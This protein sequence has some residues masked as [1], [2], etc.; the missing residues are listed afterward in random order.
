MTCLEPLVYAHK[1]ILAYQ[2]LLRYD[3]CFFAF[4]EE[5]MNV[6]ETVKQLFFKVANENGWLTQDRQKSAEVAIKEMAKEMLID[7]EPIEKIAKWTKL[8][9]ETVASL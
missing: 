8:P 5:A 6:S 4:F 1:P 9:S 2:E 7:G 3:L